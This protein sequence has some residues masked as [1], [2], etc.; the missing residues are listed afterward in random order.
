MEGLLPGRS[1][2]SAAGLAP[3]SHPPVHWSPRHEFP[4]PSGGLRILVGMIRGGGGLTVEEGVE[5]F[6]K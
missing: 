6:E 3:P 2:P 4:L 5:Q 1:G